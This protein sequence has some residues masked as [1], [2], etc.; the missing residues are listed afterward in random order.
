MSPGSPPEWEEFRRTMRALE[1]RVAHLEACLGQTPT[2]GAHLSPVPLA[3]CSAA[4][5]LAALSAGAG[6]VPVVGRALLGIAGAYLLRALSESHAIPQL[7]ATSVGILYSILW[8]AWAA[9]AA[10]VRGVGAVLY[11]LT[12]SLILAPLLWES[13]IRFHTVPTWA[14]AVVL[15]LFTAFGMVVSWRRNLL[16]V[17]TIATLTGIISAAALLIGSYDLLPFTVLLLAIAAAVE[18]SARRNDWLSERWL[19]ALAADLAVLLAAILVTRPGGLPEGYAPVSRA[20]LLATLLAL[21]AIYLGSIVVRTLFHGFA[22]TGFETAQLALALFL[23]V[24]GGLRLAGG[25][26]G[27]ALALAAVCLAAGVACY[28]LAF[29]L[30]PGRNAQTYAALGLLLVLAGTRIALPSPTAVAVW[31]ALAITCLAWPRQALRGHATAYMFLALLASGTMT[32]GTRILLGGDPPVPVPAAL[33]WQGAAA[34]LCWGI[35]SR[36]QAPR[37]F[38]AILAAATVWLFGGILAAGLTSL[39]HTIFGT[40]APHAYCAMLRTAVLA[41]GALLLATASRGKRSELVPL[42]YLLMALG[43]YRLFFL[44]LR[45]EIK[46]AVVLSLLVYGAAL[47]L[48]PRFMQRGQAAG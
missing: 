14:A 11:S 4:P 35:A 45:Q 5:A 22:F 40:L 1:A 32:S 9:R 38:R 20:A 33:S 31:T 28:A 26:S 18:I 3:A 6:A 16:V 24:G 48:L 13:T 25:D 37:L 21:A 39:Y 42:V 12:G 8:L 15:L 27:M 46:A 10:P 41:A 47:T 36:R 34:A 44:D 29:R 7:V 17:A 2:A 19:V 43:A 23:A 30:R